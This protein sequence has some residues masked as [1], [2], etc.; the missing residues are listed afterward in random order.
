[1]RRRQFLIGCA[2]AACSTA[3]HGGD[4]IEPHMH[5]VPAPGAPQVAVTLDACMGD[6]D[7]RILNVLVA[8]DIAAT[9][10]ATRRWLEHN[11]AAIKTLLAHRDL[12]KV[13]N[14]GAQHVACLIGNERPYGL[15]SAETANGVF[16][17]VIGGQQ[18]VTA[19]FGIAPKWFRDAGAVYTRDA[20]SLIDVMNFKIAG[21]S[22]NGDIGAT[23]S[24]DIAAERISAAKSGDIIISHINQPTRPAGAGVA[25]GLLALKA[26]GFSFVHLDDVQ[27]ARIA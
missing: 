23:V 18:A 10:F 27:V 3:A 9:I 17:E 7:A 24:T 8:N 1:M 25:E 15:P 13:E 6:V 5:F 20:V 19:A 12:L 26:R 14:H 4:W 21:F 2:C 16:A 22:L 11:P